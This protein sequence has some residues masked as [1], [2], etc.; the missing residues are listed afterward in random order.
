[1]NAQEYRYVL[2]VVRSAT[3]NGTDEEAKQYH[4][5]YHQSADIMTLLI[6][7]GFRES[8]W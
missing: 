4:Q 1:M 7:G 3:A 8:N 5:E 2:D 6:V